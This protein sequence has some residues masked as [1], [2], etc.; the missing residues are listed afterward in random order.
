[1]LGKRKRHT[2]SLPPLSSP[3]LSP[4]LS[5]HFCPPP[6][7]TPAPSET[8]LTEDNLATHNAA[9]APKKANSA[10]VANSDIAPPSTTS[11]LKSNLDSI[12]RTYRIFLDRHEQMPSELALLIS[13]ISAPRKGPVTPKSKEVVRIYPDT[14]AMK[15]M[16]AII[17]LEDYLGYKGEFADGGEPLVYRAHDH[18]WRE[19]S[20][21]RP[22]TRKD[23]VLKAA[24][25]AVGAPPKPKPDISYGYSTKTLTVSEQDVLANLPKN[26]S[27]TTE[28]PYFPY[29]IIE[30]KADKTKG[31]LWDA[32]RQAMRDGA[33]AVNAIHNFFASMGRDARCAETAV[34]SA[35]ISSSEFRVRVHWRRPSP[36]GH[37]TWEADQIGVGLLQR[38]EDVFLIRSII[39]NV[40]EW[41]RGQRF[42]AIRSAMKGRA[43]KFEQD[44]TAGLVE[45]TALMPNL[46][47]LEESECQRYVAN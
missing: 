41:A 27:V 26:T 9:M 36:E 20:I 32:D 12:F 2:L 47:A 44:V 4:L 15:E 37:T 5:P 7:T 28:Q 45:E 40:L 11:S 3:P 14:S 23:A 21:P 16:D 18:V 24:L 22:D 33:A 29:F 6:V 42:S 17:A 34:F 25:Q 31:T 46:S 1:M 43:D 8:L 39:L 10:I 30:W 13:Q 35:S 19:D 38:V